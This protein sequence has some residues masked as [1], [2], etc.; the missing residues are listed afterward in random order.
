MKEWKCCKRGDDEELG[1]LLLK[2]S[3]AQRGK[4]E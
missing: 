1:V 3:S 4:N 2:L